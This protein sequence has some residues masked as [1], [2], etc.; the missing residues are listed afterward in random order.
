MAVRNAFAVQTLIACL[1]LSASVGA[2]TYYVRPDGDDAAD[3]TSPQ[4]AW[5]SIDRGQPT[6]LVRR[7]SKGDRVLYV[8]KAS[9]FPPKGRLRIGDSIVRYSARTID[10]FVGCEGTPDAD[11]GTLV[12]SLEYS[13]PGPGDTVVVGPGVYF[14]PL[15]PALTDNAPPAVVTLRRGGRPGKPLQ[16]V[17]RG[18]VIID[19]RLD[20]ACINVSHATDVVIRGFHLRRGGVYVWQSRRVRVLGNRVYEGPRGIFLTYSSECEVARNLVFDFYGAWTAHGIT[21]GPGSGH[22]VH[23]NTIVA[24]GYGIRCFG[25]RNVRLERNL[26]TWCREGIVFD[27][28]SPPEAVTI[29]RNNLWACGQ[30]TWLQR[31]EDAPRNFYR[32]VR[33]TPTT[34]THVDPQIVQWDP[35]QPHFLALAASSPCVSNGRAIVGAIAKPADYPSAGNPPGQNLVFN[36]SFEAGVL[37]WYVAF[38]Q[39]VRG[40]DVGYEILTG[41]APHGRNY[42]RLWEQPRETGPAAG[43]RFQSRMFRYT[44]GQPITVSFWARSAEPDTSLSVVLTVPSWQNKSGVGQRVR[45]G[46]KWRLYRVTLQPPPWFPD[47]A[48]VEF[49]I[50]PGTVWLDGVVA[51][52]GSPPLPDEELLEL[53]PAQP[54]RVLLAPGEPLRCRLLNHSAVARSVEVRWRVSEPFGAIL[55]EGTRRV[56]VEG[57][58]QSQLL[59]APPGR[60]GAYL[61][62]YE[63]SEASGGHR[64]TGAFRFTVGV[65]APRSGRNHSFFAATPSFYAS[66]PARWRQQCR[67]LAALG[68]GTFHVY[69]GLES[70]R[71]LL[72]PDG[73]AERRIDQ[74]LQEGLQWLVTPSDAEL[75]TGKK[76]WAPAPDHAGGIIIRRTET[77]ASETAGRCTPEQLRQWAAILRRVAERYKGRVR[78]WEVLNEPNV[79][80]SGDEYS[81]VLKVS[82][83]AIRAADP[84]ALILA[85]SVVNAHRGPLY[86]ATMKMPPGTF[87]AFSFHPYRFGLLDPESDQQNFRRMLQEIKVDL[88]AGGHPPV[89]FCTE[90]GM[91]NGL[92]ETRCIRHR[93]SYSSIVRQARFGAGEVLQALYGTRMMLTALGEGCIGYSYHT[94]QGLV[95]DCLMQPMLLLNAI[96]TMDTW[97][98]DARPAARLSLGPDYRGYLFIDAGGGLVATIW[99]RDALYAAPVPV[100]LKGIAVREACDL[101]GRSLPVQSN[102]DGSRLKFGREIVFLRLGDVPIERVTRRLREAFRTLSSRPSAR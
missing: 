92:H 33:P 93:L 63:L 95:R 62:E 19:G 50:R 51:Y 58:G 7:A 32:N 15:S 22:R 84:A 67:I 72:K 27:T 76:A 28:K 8:A 3:G 45:L 11:P 26:I 49:S 70:M 30:W 97:L 79:F 100:F 14:Q 23:H 68:L 54:A 87:D 17:A 2:E 86:K 74:A 102:A 20:M 24:S 61:L 47:V 60:G 64:S 43:L 75:L 57:H 52:E 13:C 42:V 12:E 99:A 21:I 81:R 44:R 98:A 78:Y 71:E 55:S 77:T 41:N 101:F 46:P 89:V 56:T 53:L 82:S 80:L 66:L 16:Y 25:T 69:G 34:D 83:A 1:I 37:G 6:W 88:Q 29:E 91:G 48:A 35:R 39:P 96:H 38:W 9:H 65:P 18:T 31:E 73:W 94:L 10:A 85:G 36:G 4:S 59:I 5:R 40:L 90:E